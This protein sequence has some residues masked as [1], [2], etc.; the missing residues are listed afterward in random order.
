MVKLMVPQR[1]KVLR[2]NGEG[3]GQGSSK[4]TVRSNPQDS[5]NV[6]IEIENA[7]EIKTNFVCAGGESRHTL[8]LLGTSDLI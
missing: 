1:E 5:K 3:E 2:N 6:G 4:R 7:K 8:K